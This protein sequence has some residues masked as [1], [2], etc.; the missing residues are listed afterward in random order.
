VG[1]EEAPAQFALSMKPDMF[2]EAMMANRKSFR[3][4]A[5]V[6]D[7]EVTKID[8]SQLYVQLEVSSVLV[9][10]VQSPALDF[11]KTVNK[12]VTM[13]PGLKLDNV[14]GLIGDLAIP[15]GDYTEIH[16]YITSVTIYKEKIE[17]P[18]LKSDKDFTLKFK[19]PFSIL[20]DKPNAIKVKL[21]TSKF[22]AQ[23]PVGGLMVRMYVGSLEVNGVNNSNSSSEFYDVDNPISL[24]YFS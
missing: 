10:S 18:I 6:W 7:P 2:N 20:K 9:R 3:A 4:D 11:V 22:L 1:F 21:S 14:A 19:A 8:L 24:Y 15:P 16:L 23:S 17:V 13:S 12:K 5:N